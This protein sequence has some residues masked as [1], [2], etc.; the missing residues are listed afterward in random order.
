MHLHHNFINSIDCTPLFQPSV[1]KVALID[2]AL[3][4]LF[5]TAFF[6][7]AYL[8]KRIDSVDIAWGL[9]FV[10][11]AVATALHRPSFR[12]YVIALIVAV[13]GVRLAVHI[14]LRARGKKEDPRYIELTKKWKGNYWLRAY[15]SIFLTQGLLM[16]AVASP[17]I[18]ASGPANLDWQWLTLAGAYI[19]AIGFAFE[20]IAD[21]QL[22]NYLKDKKRPKVLKTGLWKYS[23]H[24]N[25]FGEL[26]QWWGI[27]IIALQAKWGFVGLI[28]P[29]LISYLIIFVSGIPPIE[30]RRAK[31]AEYREYQKTTSALVPLPPKK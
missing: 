5:M 15:V 21:M 2:V 31:D 4:F 28:G 13:W 20:A 16:L 27:G 12:S 3:V 30:K 24:P 6:L 14:G 18:V 23:R 1:L 10:L 17:I 22:A 9:G 29:L 11:I 8:R 7:V 19:W 25:Y 26:A